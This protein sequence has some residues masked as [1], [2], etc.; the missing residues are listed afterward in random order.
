MALAFQRTLRALDA[1]SH[2]RSIVAVVCGLALLGGWSAWLFGSKV[3]VYT[4]SSAARVE[5][6]AAA[7]R[8]EVPVAG[9]VVET[10]LALGREVKQGELLLRLDASQL[11][12]DRKKLLAERSTL[13]TRV[14]ALGQELAAEKAALGATRLVARR[15][16][17][18]ARAQ[19]RASRI[20]RDFSQEKARRYGKALAGAVSVVEQLKAKAEAKRL[21]AEAERA[22]R[23]VARLK[24]EK[25]AERVQR[26]VRLTR[27]RRDIALARAELSVKAATVARLEADIAKRTVWAPI[28]GRI[29]AVDELRPG[30]YVQAG[31]KLCVVIPMGKLRLVARFPARTAAGRLAQGQRAEVRFDAFPYLEYGVARARVLRVAR[32]AADGQLRVELALDGDVPARVRLVHGLTASVHVTVEQVSPAILALR[33]AG[34]SFDGAEEPASD[35]R[36]GTATGAK[37]SAGARR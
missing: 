34:K 26:R 23:G 8:V 5:A 4:T 18:E 19:R 20:A 32:E 13:Q 14:A 2:R 17:D 1:D 12:L 21:A 27:L 25:R 15:A 10:R 30:S 3:T 35:K 37:G 24:S 29:D 33:A 7:H 16:V 9:A 6:V 36:P 22:S 28:S 11:E 31:R